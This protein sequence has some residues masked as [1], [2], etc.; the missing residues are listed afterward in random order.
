MANIILPKVSEGSSF[1]ILEKVLSDENILESY[2][3]IRDDQVNLMP[4]N[5]SK[6]L[7]FDLVF[8]LNLHEWVFPLKHPINGDVKHLKYESWQQDL[9][10]ALYRYQA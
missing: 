10:I 2:K 9:T 5:K 3:P 7:E 8:H 1:E 4:L 6:G